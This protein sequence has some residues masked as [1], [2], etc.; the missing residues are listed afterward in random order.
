MREVKIEM[1]EDELNF[2]NR[3]KR[4]QREIEESKRKVTENRNKLYLSN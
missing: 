1:S 2:M 3:Q 4:V